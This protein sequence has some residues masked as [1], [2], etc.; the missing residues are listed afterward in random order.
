MPFFA[1]QFD[2]WLA[3]LRA[4]AQVDKRFHFIAL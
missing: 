4:L 2:G 3:I 1:A